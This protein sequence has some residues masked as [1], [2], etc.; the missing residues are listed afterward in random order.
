MIVSKRQLK[1]KKEASDLPIQM[2]QSDTR[3]SNIQQ[4]EHSSMLRFH[5]TEA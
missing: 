1:I 4:F 5:I 2:N 3:F